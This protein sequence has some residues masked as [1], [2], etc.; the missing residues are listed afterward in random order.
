MSDAPSCSTFIA[1]ALA[2]SISRTITA[3]LDR[4]KVLQQVGTNVR[5]VSCL[6]REGGV[7]NLFRGNSA[8]V[9]KSV[10]EVGVKFW[11]FDL[12][13]HRSSSRSRAGK[14]SML[15]RLASGAVAG[16]ASCVVVYPLEVVKTRMSLPNQYRGIADCIASIVHHEGPLALTQGLGA[17]LLGIVPFC[18]LDLALYSATK[19]RAAAWQERAE[20]SSGAVFACGA[21]STCVAQVA[22]YPLAVVRTVMQAGG[23]A[24][25]PRYTSIAEC[26]KQVVRHGGG[27]GALYRGLRPNLLKGVPAMSVTYLVFENAKRLLAGASS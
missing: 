15:D 5:G 16:V 24:G 1:G 25:H 10:P 7:P 2:G 12:I 4:L 17:S 14:P 9:V 11:I 21:F 3:P 20:P 13:Q 18:A 19:E 23:V 22:T 8:N 26:T 27:A 6:Y